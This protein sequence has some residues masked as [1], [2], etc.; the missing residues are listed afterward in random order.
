MGVASNSWYCVPLMLDVVA[1]LNLM[2]GIALSFRQ[3]RWQIFLCL[4]AMKHGHL[5]CLVRMC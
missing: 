5:K 2:A 1:F 4:Y 3:I